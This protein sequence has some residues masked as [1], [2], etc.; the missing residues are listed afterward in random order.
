MY[1]AIAIRPKQPTF[2]LLWVS[3]HGSW[4]LGTT[5]GS[6]VCWVSILS[7]TQTVSVLAAGAGSAAARAEADGRADLYDGEANSWMSWWWW[8]LFF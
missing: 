1:L 3:V 5:G 7:E 2:F 6:G 8:A 4:P